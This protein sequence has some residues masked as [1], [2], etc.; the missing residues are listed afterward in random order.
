MKKNI[1]IMMTAAALFLSGCAT[2]TAVMNS[3]SQE[4]SFESSQAFFISG[5][6]QSKTIPAHEVCGSAE[7]VAKVQ[8]VQEPLDVVL[9][10]V[11]LGIY[12]PRTA[13]VYCR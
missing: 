3:G 9:G 12:T 11:T 2:Q 8:T 4:A 7:R 6:G 10:V 5:I 13:K 1:A